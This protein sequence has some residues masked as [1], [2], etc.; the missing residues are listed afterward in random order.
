[1]AGEFQ[2]F[3]EAQAPVYQQV[4]AELSA[5]EKRTHWMWFVF[6]QLKG[7]GHSSMARKF[8]IESLDQAQRYAQHPVLGQR[9]RDCTEL[10]LK[11]Q[12]RNLSEIFGY[13]DDLKFHSCITLFTIAVPDELMFESAL[14]RY[15]NGRKDEQTIAILKAWG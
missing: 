1:M 2:H 8:A 14:Q 15:F 6:P 12:G 11:V 3:L 7:L 5:G 13:P 10:V 4:L 9:L